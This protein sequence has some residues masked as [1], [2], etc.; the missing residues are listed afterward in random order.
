MKAKSKSSKTKEVEFSYY[1]PN[2]ESV[3][4][5]GTFNDW[6]TKKNLLKFKGQGQWA[7]TLKLAKG[8]YEYRFFVDGVWQNDQNTVECVP[9]AFGTWNCALEVQ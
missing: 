4:V 5:A 8:R 2:V 7:I 9:N 1:A 3:A 6:D